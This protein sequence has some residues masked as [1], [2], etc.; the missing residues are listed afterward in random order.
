MRNFGIPDVLFILGTLPTTLLLS[1]ATIVCGLIG[2]VLLALARSS[3]IKVLQALA[4]IYIRL[5][6][7][8]PLLIQILVAFFAPS[9][10]LGTDVSGWTAALIA[11]TLNAI[12]YAAEIIRGCLEAVPRGQWEASRALGLNYIDRMRD[13]VLPQAFR[14]AVPP[15]IGLGVQIVKGTSLASVVGL[16]E[17]TKAANRVNA[18]TFEPIPAFGTVCIAYFAICWPLSMLGR[19]LER[20]RRF[21]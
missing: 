1:L 21:A 16:V 6:Q 20:K 19:H 8:T 10:F 13:I 4:V 3:D 17:L 12:A 15:L 5:F 7:G 2:G 14:I 18:L 11:L 9:F